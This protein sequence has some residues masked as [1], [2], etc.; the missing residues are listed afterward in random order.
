MPDIDCSGLACPRPVLEARK[1]LQETSS[2]FTVLVD[3]PTARD[4]VSRFARSSGCGVEVNDESGKYLL[5][6]TPPESP[7]GS[8]LPGG[9]RAAPVSINRKRVMVISA[10]EIGRGERE[11]GLTLMKMFLYTATQSDTPPSTMIFMNSGVRLVTENE[12]TSAHVAGLEK[13]GVEVMVCG[14]CLDYYGLKDELRAGRVSNMYEIQSAMLG[15]DLLV[16]L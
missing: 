8:E 1:R 6:V 5:T 9:A 12:E 14:T 4:N 10:D 11:L 2:P 3:N 16:S 13:A 15:A 7:A